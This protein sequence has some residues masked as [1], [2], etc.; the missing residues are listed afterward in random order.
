[1]ALARVSRP[2]IPQRWKELAPLFDAALDLEPPE[3]SAFLDRACADDTDLRAELETLLA[4]CAASD[5][6]FD[7]WRRGAVCGAS[8]HA[9]SRLAGDG[10]RALPNRSRDRHR[11]NGEPVYLARDL[12]HDRD[13]ALKVVRADLSA[14]LGAERFLAEVRINAKLD[15]PHILTLIDSGSADGIL[16]YVL[17]FVRG[18]DAAR[19]VGARTSAFF[20]GSLF[21]LH[22]SWPRRSTTRT[23]RAWYTA[24]SSRKTILLHEGEA[25]LADFG[26]AL[27]VER[28]RWEQAHRLRPL[29]RHTGV[30]ESRAGT[31]DRELDG[32]SDVY[33]LAAVLYEMLAGEPPI[34]SASK[35]TVIAKLLTERPTRLSIVRAVPDEVDRAV[36]KALS[37]VPADPVRDS[38]RIRSRARDSRRR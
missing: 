6:L 2:V 5:Q 21:R 4:E 15:H 10:G 3:R 17:P 8:D 20:R 36:D 34:T 30:Y 28:G 7:C 35:Q 25:V 29:A 11:G 1:M 9:A 22:D 38:R 32:R 18:R 19:E 23:R 33:S 14:I 12:K 37:K 26:I 24:T 16:F 31:G 13:V 27:A